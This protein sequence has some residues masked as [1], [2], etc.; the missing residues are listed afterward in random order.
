MNKL[1]SYVFILLV[2]SYGLTAYAAAEVGLQTPKG[3][4]YG[5]LELP[6]NIEKPDIVLIIGGSGPTNRDGNNRYAGKNN[7]LKFF[8]DAL[9]D[10][11]IASLRYDKRGI[12]A[13]SS[14]AIPEQDLVFE[15]FVND[16][17]L[18][19]EQI[20]KDERFGK[21]IIA[22]HSE[23]SL[24][25]ALT[26]IKAKADALISLNGA[27]R[28]AYEVID[29][30]FMNNAPQFR[31]DALAIMDSLRK[32]KQVERI[33][34]V[35]LAVFRPDIQPYLISYFKYDPAQVYSVVAMPILIAQGTTDLQVYLKDAE[36][37]A[38]SN[39]LSKL[40][41]I[42]GMNHILKEVPNDYQT[43]ADS[44]NNPN[45]PVSQK[46]KDVTNEFIKALP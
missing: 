23:G 41:I 20:R 26:A 28:P 29:E 4:L 5:T 46:L 2:L 40:V 44:Y 34:D 3:V 11:G 19:A 22:G 18:W 32:G 7:S 13:S 31:E 6:E 15:T 12:A 35:L 43:Q 21:L 9:K 10:N 39:N 45:M 16:A 14:A 27:G 30:Q 36:R 25:A 8:A 37:L 17:V 38:K 33:P 1:I 42:E 24:I